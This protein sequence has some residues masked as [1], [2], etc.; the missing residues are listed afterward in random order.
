MVGSAPMN[1]QLTLAT[2][3][4]SYRLTGDLAVELTEM[5]GLEV[6]VWGEAGS[7]P[8]PLAAG[9]IDVSRYRILD[10]DGRPVY[11]GEITRLSSRGATLRTDDGEEIVLSSVPDDFRVGQRV[12]VQGP[13]GIA[14]QTFGILK[15]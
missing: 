2:T 14:V 9:S 4:G 15:P 5:V 3:A 6:E 8:D 10:I 1:T 11:V 12:W 13:E 7:T